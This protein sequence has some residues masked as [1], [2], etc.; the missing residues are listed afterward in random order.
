MFIDQQRVT[1]TLRQEGH[2]KFEE[3]LNT[4]AHG[5]RRGWTALVCWSINIPLLA[6]GENSTL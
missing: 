3:L 2:V 1:F 4:K 6:E 5:P